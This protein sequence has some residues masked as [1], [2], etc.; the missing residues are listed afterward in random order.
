MNQIQTIRNGATGQ[1]EEYLGQSVK[2]EPAQ[3]QAMRDMKDK[4]AKAAEAAKKFEK[5]KTIPAGKA[6][7]VPAEEREGK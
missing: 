5:E 7:A 2:Q 3:E 1:L 6:T 4:S